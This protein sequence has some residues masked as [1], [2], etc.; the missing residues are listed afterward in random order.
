MFLQIKDKWPDAKLSLNEWKAIQNNWNQSFPG[1]KTAKV[2]SD[3][4][5]SEY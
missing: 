2:V 3:C 4:K 5:I 1:D